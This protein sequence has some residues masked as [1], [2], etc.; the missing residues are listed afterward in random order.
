[1][2]IKLLNI[3]VKK[4]EKRLRQLQ[5]AE[6]EEANAYFFG[7]SICNKPVINIEIQNQ[8]III[9]S[10]LKRFGILVS[11]IDKIKNIIRKKEFNKIDRILESKGYDGLDFYC[12]QCNKI[13]C[14]QH[15][16]L[17]QIYAYDGQKEHVIARCPN[18]HEKI[19]EV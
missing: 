9:G 16:K 10:I 14:P 12:P 8:I 1:M 5:Q 17:I 6:Q 15:Y 13:F 19:V 7:C 18:N 4:Q 2:P 3:G 11:D